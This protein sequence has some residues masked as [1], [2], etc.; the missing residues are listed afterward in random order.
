MGSHIL[1][2]LSLSGRY[3]LTVL[4]RSDSHPPLTHGVAVVQVDYDSDQSLRS[5]LQGHDVLVSALGKKALCLQPRLIDAAVAVGVERIIPSEYGGNLRNP[6]TRQFPTYR[7][8][9]L[10]EELLERHHLHSG[11]SYSFIYNNCFLDWGISATGGTL[12]NPST[13]SVRLY[14]GGDV[15]FSATTM[16]TVGRAVVAVLD[17]YDETANRTVY[18]HDIVITQNQLLEMAREAT[19]GDGGKDWDCSDV[20]TAAA[21]AAS[22]TAFEK[23]P[24]DPTI[25]YGFAIRGAFGQGYG[26][27]FVDS[28]NEMLGIKEMTLSQVKDLVREH[29]SIK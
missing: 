6:K 7:S 8:K 4:V 9:V 14:D 16:A 17:H 3:E 28:D 20:D 15:K 2:A 22:Y 27:H 13:R 1:S 5:A 11:I 10:V 25:F 23:N 29:V 21:E 18:V 24:A 26:G 12:L 19:S